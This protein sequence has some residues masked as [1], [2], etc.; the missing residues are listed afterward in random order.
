[1]P[2][3]RGG[4][5][6][7]IETHAIA[8]FGA[9]AL[10][11]S[12]PRCGLLAFNCPPSLA[13]MADERA[14][15]G[16]PGQ[17]LLRLQQTPHD[18]A[19]SENSLWHIGRTVAVQCKGALSRHADEVDVFTC[20]WGRGFNVMTDGHY[21]FWREGCTWHA[22]AYPPQALRGSGYFSALRQSGRELLVVQD[23]A[24][25]GTRVRERVQLLQR[26]Q[27]HWK[28]LWL[29]SPHVE[30]DSSKVSLPDRGIDAFKVQAVDGSFHLHR[31][32]WIR[33]GT[34]YM[35]E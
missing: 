8:R 10:L 20:Q 7:M 3:L 2:R 35:R 30:V 21:L 26:G 12:V 24:G 28:V 33:S 34:G 13:Q 22:Q 17:I 23:S 27:R 15:S 19:L 1:M 25:G 4:T 5:E 29:S 31:E 11:I 9:L 32:K 6:R 14:P 16:V 18:L